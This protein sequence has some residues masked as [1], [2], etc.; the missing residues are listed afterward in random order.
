MSLLVSDSDDDDPFVV[1]AIPTGASSPSGFEMTTTEDAAAPVASAGASAGATPLLTI[2]DDDGADRAQGN[3][4]AAAAAS[5]AGTTTSMDASLHQSP[6]SPAL[7]PTPDMTH[8]NTRSPG[9][10]A[11]LRHNLDMLLGA[12]HLFASPEQQIPPPPY[13]WRPDGLSPPWTARSEV[14]RTFEE[15]VAKVE[16]RCSQ[17]VGVSQ[18][19]ARIVNQRHGYPGTT[20]VASV[21]ALLEATAPSY[22]ARYKALLE[23]ELCKFRRQDREASTKFL[24]RVKTAFGTGSD[25]HSCC[26]AVLDEHPLYFRAD[27]AL[28]V[29]HQRL[30]TLFRNHGYIL[31]DFAT[32][33]PHVAAAVQRQA[34][35]AAA[36]ARSQKKRRRVSSSEHNDRGDASNADGVRRAGTRD[37]CTRGADQNGADEDEDE[38]EMGSYD[39]SDGDC[40]GDG[41]DRDQQRD[42]DSRDDNGDN[43]DHSCRGERCRS[44]RPN[45]SQH[46]EDNEPSRQGTT[47]V[48][49]LP[50]PGLGL[51][52]IRQHLECPV[53]MHPNVDPVS[54]PCGHVTCRSCAERCVRESKSCPICRHGTTDASRLVPVLVLK[55]MAWAAFQATCGLGGCSF[56]SIPDSS[57]WLEHVRDCP[58]RLLGCRNTGCSQVFTAQKQHEHQCEHVLCEGHAYCHGKGAMHVADCP[59]AR[60]MSDLKARHRAELDALRSEKESLSRR[61]QQEMRRSHRDDRRRR[62]VE[63]RAERARTQ[64]IAAEAGV[65]GGG[66]SNGGRFLVTAAD[67]VPRTP[68]ARLDIDSTNDDALDGLAA[69]RSSLVQRAR[70][71][72]H[73]VDEFTPTRRSTRFAFRR[74]PNSDDLVAATAPPPPSLA[75]AGLFGFERRPEASDTR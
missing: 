61:L 57:G 66:G 44:K 30:D 40:N 41:D 28:V 34:K 9:D 37:S 15:L 13:P 36:R 62:L 39:S 33:F 45:N 71:T 73:H 29:L 60:A 10:G 64:R 4:A 70:P 38:D 27:Y 26:K 19:F 74:R 32:D 31:D 56:S 59:V 72:P 1:A 55:D 5:A 20:S 52:F 21:A 12:A 58:L 43:D 46:D 49:K 65:M 24:D 7:V 3:A 63:E 42:D 8:I 69:F 54:F 50:A 22:V 68:A 18:E 35:A 53:L 25:M 2:S 23:E 51:D 48:S 67:P 17:D 6:W 47:A 75:M 16:Q 14:A 11:A